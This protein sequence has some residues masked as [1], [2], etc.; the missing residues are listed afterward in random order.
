VQ[1][2]FHSVELRLQSNSLALPDGLCR[3][4]F[5][6]LTG[7]PIVEFGSESVPRLLFRSYSV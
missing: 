5:L 6:P 2:R 3:L 1:L 4:E 7:K